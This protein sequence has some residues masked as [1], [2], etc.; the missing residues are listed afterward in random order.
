MLREK[1]R[2]NYIC[3]KG[4]NSYAMSK[5]YRLVPIDYVTGTVEDV[6]SVS[7]FKTTR[8][9]REIKPY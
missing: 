2:G 6:L 5:K 3:M 7:Y 9:L 8:E 1:L 4:G